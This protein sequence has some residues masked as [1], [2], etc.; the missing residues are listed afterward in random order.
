LL[1]QG[2]ETCPSGVAVLCLCA[3]FSAV[4]NE[5]AL[6]RHAPARK[7]AQ[8]RFDMWGKRRRAD[9]EA[10]FNRSGDLVYILAAGPRRS[11][12]SLL[13]LALVRRKRTVDRISGHS[14]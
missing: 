2:G 11:H 9:I 4:E 10:Q 1:N 6:G 5:H 13:D 8:A 12:E 3:M 14:I 7:S